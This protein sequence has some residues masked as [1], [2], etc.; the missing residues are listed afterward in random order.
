ML[1]TGLVRSHPTIA[2]CHPVGHP[3]G[4]VSCPAAATLQ[5]M[6]APAPPYY[7]TLVAA[8]Q[9]AS[10]S[11]LGASFMVAPSLCTVT[12]VV[13]PSRPIAATFQA[14]LVAPAHSVAGLLS[15]D[16]KPTYSCWGVAPVVG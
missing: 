16:I 11:S 3:A 10:S 4:A 8:L 6:V 12:P 5:A 2:H 15:S 13:P 9:L 14:K 1:R 7:I